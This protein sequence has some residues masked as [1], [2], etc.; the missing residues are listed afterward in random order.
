MMGGTQNN[1]HELGFSSSG[2]FYVV[3]NTVT[4]LRYAARTTYSVVSPT[5]VWFSLPNSA[6]ELYINNNDSISA[7]F[8]VY[9]GT[10]PNEFRWVSGRGIYLARRQEVNG[11][12][13]FMRMNVKELAIFTS[14]LSA[15]QIKLFRN[16]MLTRYP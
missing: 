7:T 3:D 2:Y 10:Y 4:T 8:E 12:N 5:L 14:S 11:A 9:F 1:I 6:P 13:G 16:D 15:D